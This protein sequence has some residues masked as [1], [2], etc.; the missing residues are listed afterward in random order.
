MGMALAIRTV[1][2]SSQA[3]FEQNFLTAACC[4]FETAVPHQVTVHDFP[5]ENK[6]NHD[7]DPP[8][9]PAASIN[10]VSI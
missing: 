9:A 1:V 5:H 2:P 7:P 6:T 8:R 4:H 3:S 10:V